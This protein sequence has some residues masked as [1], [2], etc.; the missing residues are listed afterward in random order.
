MLLA[1]IAITW[2]VLAALAAVGGPPGVALPPNLLQHAHLV[3]TVSR[4]WPVLWQTDTQVLLYP[5]GHDRLLAVMLGSHRNVSGVALPP[6]PFDDEAKE[7]QYAIGSSIIESGL[8]IDATFYLPAGAKVL[9]EAQFSTYKGTR[10]SDRWA[11]IAEIPSGDGMP[12][13]VSTS[14]KGTDASVVGLWI[15]TLPQRHVQLVGIMPSHTFWASPATVEGPLQE[16]DYGMPA[17]CLTW[18]PSGRS[19]SLVVGH[20]LYIIDTG[21]SHTQ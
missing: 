7:R 3:T 20:S 2:R 18:L 6:A 5:G 15:V 4:V 16:G 12:G 21:M 10:A 19:V 11:V 9:A 8:R 17:H 14:R 13:N 1:K